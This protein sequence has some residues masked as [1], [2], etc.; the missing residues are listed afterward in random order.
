MS[1]KKSAATKYQSKKFPAKVR[2]AA[3]E[4]A[5]AKRARKKIGEMAFG[6]PKSSKIHREYREV[7]GIYQKT[8]RK[9]AKLTGYTWKTR[10]K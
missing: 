8:G 6:K 5:L 7:D 2:E 1:A 3:A 9:L 10:R 4:H